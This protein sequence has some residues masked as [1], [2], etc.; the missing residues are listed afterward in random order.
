MIS[1]MYR[2]ALAGSAALAVWA[3]AAPANAVP[4]LYCKDGPAIDL[5]TTGCI[6][7]T[8]RGYP[9]GGD[10]IYSNAGGGDPVAAVQT[11]IF[12]ATGANVALTLYGKSDSNPSLFTFTPTDPAT[13]NAGTWDVVNNSIFIKYITVKAANSY[14]LYELPG[15]GAN[16]GN[17]STLGILNN[18][19]QRPDVSHISFWTAA[20]GGPKGGVPE[21]GEWAMMLA[22]FGMIGAVFRQRRQAPRHTPA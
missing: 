13:A 11:A 22:G 1:M 19:G 12:G 9:G 10:G 14:A 20:S 2:L 4:V 7:G 8:A 6:S 3:V 18:G 5:V 21:P 17:F 16:S 15:A